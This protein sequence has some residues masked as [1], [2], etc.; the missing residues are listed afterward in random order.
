MFPTSSS[1]A[2]F[3]IHFDSHLSVNQ[4]RFT[5][6]FKPLR[7]HFISYGTPHQLL[8][9]SQARAIS[10]DR[11]KPIRDIYAGM[12][13]TKRSDATTQKSPTSR[14]KNKNENNDKSVQP[15]EDTQ[16][17]ATRET[18]EESSDSDYGEV[19]EKSRSSQASNGKAR[20]Q[21]LAKPAT[22]KA[23]SRRAA[24]YAKKLGLT[25]AMLKDKP[26]L[27]PKQYWNFIEGLYRTTHELGAENLKLKNQ[28][29]QQKNTTDTL[30]LRN[31]DLEKKCEKHKRQ[32]ER[33]R[34][35]HAGY[36]D[37]IKS[38]RDDNLALLDFGVVE[39]DTD[40]YVKDASETL[41]KQSRAWTYSWSLNDWSNT[42]ETDMS[43]IVASLRNTKAGAIATDAAIA[44]VSKRQINPKYL[45]N[46]IC[47]HIICYYTLVHPFDKLR[48][49]GPNGNITT[50]PSIVEHL[51]HLMK[52]SEYLPFS[53]V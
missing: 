21:K 38:L 50:S 11:D 2:L 28:K 24:I 4:F 43:E 17:D 34:S 14:P 5:S 40:N 9:L 25:P 16:D 7:L 46:A 35:T 53:R 26:E 1:L 42:T 20:Q 37:T 29:K 3:T 31:N 32:L 8:L 18:S 52:K 48:E 36:E 13:K 6:H 19:E 23:T 41:L 15:V 30:K 33:E 10:G 49:C 51:F 44:A 22:Q 39:V 27:S 12:A 45:L 47:N